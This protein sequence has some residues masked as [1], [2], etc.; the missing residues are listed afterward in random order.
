MALRLGR[1]QDVLADVTECDAVITD[2]PYSERTHAG[3]RSCRVD[4]RDF[5]KASGGI[6]AITYSPM[7][8]EALPE[9]RAD[10]L[11]IFCDHQGWVSHEEA[12]QA[13]GLYVFQPVVW[14]NL[15][16]TP[17][18]AGDGPCSAVQY[19]AVA[20]PKRRQ[21]WHASRPGAYVGHPVKD[22]GTRLVGRKPLWLMR[23]LVSDYS[24]PGD[25][26]VDPY[27]GSGTTLL[28]AAMEGRR[29]IG[30]EMN[31]KTYELAV[32]RLSKGYTERLFRDGLTGE[33]QTAGPIAEFEAEQKRK[34]AP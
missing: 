24:R 2:P 9:I 14:V 26:I 30:A 33:Q 21:E 16:P 23:A 25:L 27:A 17:R 34:K 8:A 31:P 11:I 28:A 1:W 32:K 4:Q 20:R 19:L 7:V 12:M 3:Q 5:C 22:T 10:W 13:R 15:S 6:N 29:A 18:L